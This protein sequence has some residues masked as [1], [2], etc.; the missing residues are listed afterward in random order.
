[1]FLKI[2]VLLVDTDSPFRA[3]IGFYIDNSFT[4]S[5]EIVSLF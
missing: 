5:K 3:F 1:M 2:Q 4:T